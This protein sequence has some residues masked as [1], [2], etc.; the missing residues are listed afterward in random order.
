MNDYIYL[1]IKDEVTSINLTITDYEYDY[2]Y[3]YEKE[4][5]IATKTNV[6]KCYY[7]YSDNDGWGSVEDTI[8]SE[9]VSE[10][11]T[12]FTKL[13]NNKINEFKIE[14][15]LFVCEVKRISTYYH[16][17]FKIDDGLTGTWIQVVKDNMSKGEVEFLANA[18]ISWAKAFPVPN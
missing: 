8:P 16:V 9:D 11:A 10:F 5:D 14:K 2:E 12:L 1:S 6:L 4:I 7:N 17:D 18:V 13:I 3:D 15:R